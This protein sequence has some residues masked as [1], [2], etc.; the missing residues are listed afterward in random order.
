MSI[1]KYASILN[2]PLQEKGSYPTLRWTYG[3]GFL[4][5]L[6]RIRDNHSC[7]SC[8]K[9]WKMGQRRFDVHHENEEHEGDTG[10]KYQNNLQ[11]EKM[12]T[13]CHKCHLN[14]D[15]VT[16]RMIKGKKK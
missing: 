15:C 9:K 16:S 14:L 11:F 5:E 6:V 2:L 1:L 12:K 3:R 10:R 8:G 4:R 13:Y 7:G